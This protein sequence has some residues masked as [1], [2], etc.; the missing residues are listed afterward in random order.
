MPDDTSRP[1]LSIFAAA[2]I[3][4]QNI[5]A[6]LHRMGIANTHVIAIFLMPTGADDCFIGN[7]TA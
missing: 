2:R 3:S 4:R 7:D 6:T 1:P 5:E